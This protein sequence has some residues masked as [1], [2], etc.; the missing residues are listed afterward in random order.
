MAEPS[1][2]VHGGGMLL[3]LEPAELNALGYVQMRVSTNA[4]MAVRNRGGGDGIP[5]IQQVADLMQPILQPFLLRYATFHDLPW[6]LELEALSTSNKA[7][8]TLHQ[9]LAANPTGQARLL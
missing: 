6:L 1:I 5:H 9:R 3:E 2:S 7:E 4:L 8:A